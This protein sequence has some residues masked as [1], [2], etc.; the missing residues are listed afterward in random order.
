[1]TEDEAITILE[2]EFVSSS[3]WLSRARRGETKDGAPLAHIYEALSALSDAWAYTI[4]VPKHA[5]LPMMQVDSALCE[6]NDPQ[7]EVP[8]GLPSSLGEL[9]IRVEEVL[10][11]NDAD[12]LDIAQLFFGQNPRMVVWG[13]NSGLQDETLGRVFDFLTGNDGVM[14][15]GHFVLPLTEA[16]CGY[17]RTIFREL[18]ERDGPSKRFLACWLHGLLV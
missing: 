17:A 16:N 3:G 9:L 18:V 1:M 4:F 14:F 15:E 7:F 12:R 11:S 5:V 2:A 13:P 6:M 10:V 8:E